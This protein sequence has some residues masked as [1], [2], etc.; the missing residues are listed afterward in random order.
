MN[1]S[2]THLAHA[3]ITVL[4]VAVTIAIMHHRC[5][6]TTA[7]REAQIQ[8]A[9]ATADAVI[10]ELERR[11]AERNTLKEQIDS[12]TLVLDHN[13]SRPIYENRPRPVDSSGLR[14]AIMG[15]VAR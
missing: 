13:T 8:Q 5:A 10:T 12:L 2:T 14:N 3:A 15:A 11:T 6:I 4:A 9:A 1:Q 7:V